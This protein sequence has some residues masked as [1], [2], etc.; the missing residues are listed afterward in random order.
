MLK[1]I[2]SFSLKAEKK[3][4]F[5]FKKNV[6]IMRK[7]ISLC[8]YKIKDYKKKIIYKKYTFEKVIF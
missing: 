8:L 7:N 5:F 2:F 6:K 4:S 3:K 1:N